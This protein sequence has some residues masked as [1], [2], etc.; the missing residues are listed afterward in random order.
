MKVEPVP[1]PRRRVY[2]SIRRIDI[3]L[4]RLGGSD[5]VGEH[6]VD[7]VGIDW[8]SVASL[9]GL[10]VAKTDILISWRLPSS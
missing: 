9:H 5:D 6:H 2:E 7:P 1:N 10:A 4:D 3:A 8:Y